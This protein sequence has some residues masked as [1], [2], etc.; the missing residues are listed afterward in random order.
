MSYRTILADLTVPERVRQRLDAAKLL[1]A[2][3]DARLIG[4]H[5]MPA[6]FV[7][8]GFSGEGLAVIGPELMAS[9]ARRRV[10]LAFY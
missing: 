8:L 9:G 2:R 3:F 4:M 1:A 10:S 5:I 6:P 7:P